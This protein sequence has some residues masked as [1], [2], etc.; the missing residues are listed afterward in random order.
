MKNFFLIRYNNKIIGVYNKLEKA[1][2]FIKSCLSNNLMSGSADI[3][4]YTRNSCICINIINVT[5][6]KQQITQE[7]SFKSNPVNPPETKP[8]C[9]PVIKS[10]I[11][12]VIKPESN[13]EVKPEINFNDPKFI[14]LAEDKNNLQHKIN[15]LKVQKERFKE[16]KEIY[17]N[18]IKL[19]NKFK[20]N[21]VD[22]SQFIIPELFKEKFIIFKKLENENILNWENFIKNYNHNNIYSDYF[23]SNSYDDSFVPHEQKNSINIEFE[24]PSDTESSETD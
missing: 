16:S 22:D 18:D 4:I 3:M 10:V 24:I 5:L 19:F 2:I 23:K 12:S 15:M 6:D 20:K 14:K 21:I 1:K 17:D 8:E 7:N 13:P 9:K 11:K